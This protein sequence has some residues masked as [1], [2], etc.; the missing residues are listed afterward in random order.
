MQDA[1]LILVAVELLMGLWSLWTGFQ[2]VAMARRHIV[3][4]PGFFTPRVAL[5]CPCKGLEKGLDENLVALCSQDY[6]NYEVF[7]VFARSDDPAYAIARRVITA[8]TVPAQILLAGKPD[9]CGEKPA[10]RGRAT[11]PNIPDI[12]IR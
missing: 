8:C 6:P 7:F 12:R 4:H 1:F 9:R 11:G 10:L 2:W 3:S 5:I